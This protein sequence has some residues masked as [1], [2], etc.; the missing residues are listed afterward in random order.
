MTTHV[1]HRRPPH[2][3]ARRP[4]GLPAPPL[5]VIATL[6]LGAMGY[7]GSVLWPSWPEPPLAANAPS[8]PITVGGVVFNLP[9]AAIRVAM[10]RQPGA[11]GRVDLAFLWPSL[12]PPDPPGSAATPKQNLPRHS[13][14]V[15]VTIAA[16]GDTLA[17]A[18]RV[19]TIYSRYAAQA[20]VAG[21][22]G[23][24]VLAFRDGSPYQGEDLIYDGVTPDNFLVRCSRNGAGPTPGICLF[25]R[26]IQAADITV[27]FARDWLEDWRA[28]AGRIDALITKL[29]PHT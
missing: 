15:F 27:R 3:H 1:H 28:V 7:I 26:R 19:K 10:Q 21:P 14:R 23:L 13:D 12:D 6:V 20:P 24:A 4:R 11:H 22:G 18:E 16:A 5:I 17:P 8:M 29:R 2:L 9:P 25:S